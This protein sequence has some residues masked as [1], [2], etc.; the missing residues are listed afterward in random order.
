[1]LGLKNRKG[2]GIIE[3]VFSLSIL[4]I[5]STTVLLV[6]MNS[7]KLIA[8]NKEIEKCTVFAEG[9]KNLIVYNYTY[10]DIVNLRNTNK[11]YIRSEDVDISVL[12]DKDLMNILTKTKPKQ[13]PYA[14][15]YIEDEECETLKIT[16]NIYTK[17][18]KNN[19]VLQ[20]YKGNYDEE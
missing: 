7:L 17:V 1:M 4:M 19:I 13:K 15:L 5:F 16:L 10:A 14:V 8:Y 18:N 6:S 9:I 12:R 11:I 2:Y 3:V 20:F